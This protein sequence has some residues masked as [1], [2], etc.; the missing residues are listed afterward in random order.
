MWCSARRDSCHGLGEDSTVTVK[1][2]LVT[3]ISGQDGSYM[4]ELLLEMGYNVVGLSHSQLPHDRP[5]LERLRRRIQHTTLSSIDVSAFQRLLKEYR[6]QEIYNCAARASSSHLFAD[7]GLTC[8]VN[9][10][11]VLR[12]LEAIRM[13]DPT[14]RFCQ[15]SS[16]EMFGITA[17]SPQNEQTPFTPRN[18]YGVAKLFAHEMVC[19]YREAFGLFCCSSIL[20]N[21]ESVRRGPEFV[22][23]KIS[24]GV[25][26]AV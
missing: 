25:A 6:P 3:G 2:A 13:T 23:R 24:M 18:P 4:A 16:S 14:I 12:I 8:D 11:A 5:W 15:A 1:T 21:H 9:G 7:P 22:T 19:T 17:L 10:M 26:R 20:F